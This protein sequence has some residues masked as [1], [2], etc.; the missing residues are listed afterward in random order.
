MT[1]LVKAAKQRAVA[2][3]W[4]WKDSV[5]TCQKTNASVIRAWKRHLEP[6]TKGGEVSRVPRNAALHHKRRSSASGANWR[7]NS[8]SLWCKAMGI[9]WNFIHVLKW[10]ITQAEKKWHCGKY[11][12]ILKKTVVVCSSTCFGP[13]IIPQTHILFG[14][15]ADSPKLICIITSCPQNKLLFWCLWEWVR[16]VTLAWVTFSIKV[17]VQLN[18]NETLLK[19]QPLFIIYFSGLI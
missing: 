13:L 12:K 7:G 15:Y 4:F 1:Q 2:S 9:H 16:R 17:K 8:K 14:F 5:I 18:R 11:K 10:R 19:K 3:E 6:N